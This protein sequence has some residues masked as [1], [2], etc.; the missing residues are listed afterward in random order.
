VVLSPDSLVTGGIARQV[1]FRLTEM[2]VVLSLVNG[3]RAQPA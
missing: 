3:S 1:V 2:W